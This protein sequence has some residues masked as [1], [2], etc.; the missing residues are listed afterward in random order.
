M[1]LCEHLGCQLATWVTWE[2]PGSQSAEIFPLGHLFS[3]EEN[4][5]CVSVCLSC[6]AAVYSAFSTGQKVD[7]S[8]DKPLPLPSVTGSS[9]WQYLCDPEYSRFPQAA[10]LASIAPVLPSESSCLETASPPIPES[11]LLIFFFGH[12]FPQSLTPLL[13]FRGFLHIF[14]VWC[15]KRCFICH[16]ECA[17]L[18]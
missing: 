6:I 4:L 17:M 16:F 11:F 18:T 10:T 15:N 5:T 14:K 13:L 2:M 1:T 8:R 3:V 12:C 9:S 7:C